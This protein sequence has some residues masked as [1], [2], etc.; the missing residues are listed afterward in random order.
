MSNFGFSANCMKDVLT[1][2]IIPLGFVII[3]SQ[4]FSLKYAVYIIL[5]STDAGNAGL[6]VWLCS[7]SKNI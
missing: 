6:K 1:N 4:L 2:K 3:F 5:T 7:I